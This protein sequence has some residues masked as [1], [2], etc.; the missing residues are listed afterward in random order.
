MLCVPWPVFF[1]FIHVKHRFIWKWGRERRRLWKQALTVSP[2]AFSQKAS[3]LPIDFLSS[4]CPELVFILCVDERCGPLSPLSW[5]AVTQFLFVSFSFTLPHVG[6]SKNAE[7]RKWRIV[8]DR[9]L[10]HLWSLGSDLC[11]S[12][13]L[14]VIQ[15]A[16]CKNKQLFSPLQDDCSTH[17]DTLVQILTYIFW[18]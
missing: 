2:I 8:G 1:F 14:C 10:P 3:D 12:W 16:E 5:A 15:D 7:V 18:D 13:M 6:M 11:L 17:W 4:V 9:L